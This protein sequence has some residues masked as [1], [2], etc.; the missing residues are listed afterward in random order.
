MKGEKNEKK[1]FDPSKNLKLDSYEQEIEDS[2]DVDNIQPIENLEE[3]KK[4]YIHIFKEAAKAEKKEARLN[5]RLKRSDLDNIRERASE[6]GLPYQTL[7]N[8]ILHQ[9]AKGKI[10]IEL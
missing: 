4:R 10:K 5:I 8:T 9:F 3:E 2:I 6:N 7:I 1:Q